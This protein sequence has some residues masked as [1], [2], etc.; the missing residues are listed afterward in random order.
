MPHLLRLSDVRATAEGMQPTGYHLRGRGHL[1][2]GL[3][4]VLS[5]VA[6]PVAL[7]VFAILTAPLGGP[8]DLGAGSFSFAAGPLDILLVL[9]AALVVLPVIHELSHG[10]VAWTLGGRPVYG[11]G[12]GIAF[13]HFREFVGKWPYAAILVAPLLLISLGGALLMPLAPAILRGPLLALMVTNASGAVGD[14]AALWQLVR[15]P[16]N[17]LIADTNAG[18]E[19][20][21]PE[22]ATSAARQ[23]LPSRH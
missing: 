15:F 4:S 3:L 18:F 8:L 2:L 10:A 16:G 19:V 23:D 7:V 12:P 11:I 22:A 17:I 14:L 5:L 21:E 6:L 9:L 20:Y 1:N 13:C